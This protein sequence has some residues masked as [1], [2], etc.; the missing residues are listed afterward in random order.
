MKAD[1]EIRLEI[2]SLFF[3]PGGRVEWDGVADDA[4]KIYAWVKQGTPTG[5]AASAEAAPTAG[6]IAVSALGK[7]GQASN[8]RAKTKRSRRG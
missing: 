4:E 1:V 5:P 3:R 7:P 6:D 8:P 2:A